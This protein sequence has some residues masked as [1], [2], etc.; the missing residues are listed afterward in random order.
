MKMNYNNDEDIYDDEEES[1]LLKSFDLPEE[2]FGK[3]MIL[4]ILDAGGN[5]EDI[6]FELEDIYRYVKDVYEKY[7]EGN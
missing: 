4:Q 5:I 2:M 7:P 1:D 3:R 6:L